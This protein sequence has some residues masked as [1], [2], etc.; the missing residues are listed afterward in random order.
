LNASDIIAYNRT[1]TE[2]NRGANSE[3]LPK[4]TPLYHNGVYIGTLESVEPGMRCDCPVSNAS[5]EDGRGTDY[6]H[7][8]LLSGGD[9]GVHCSGSHCN[10]T[11]I[12]EVERARDDYSF[13]ALED[14]EVEP[15]ESVPTMW[16]DVHTEKYCYRDGDDILRMSK[17][18]FT[19]LL[20]GFG[21]PKVAEV[22][23][24]IG[25]YKMDYD[26]RSGAMIDSRTINLF[27]PSPLMDVATDYGVRYDVP[28]TIGM[29]LDNVFGKYRSAFINWLAYI[30]QRRDKTGVIWVLKGA[31]GSGKGIVTEL[32]MGE[33]FGHNMA[34]NLTDVQMTSQFNSF[35]E[36][37]MIVHFNEISAEDKLSRVTVKNKLKTW[38]TDR[39][40]EINSK[41]IRE[42][43]VGN[44]ANIIIN[45]N[46]AIPVDIDDGDRRF[47]VVRTGEALKDKEWFDPVVS[48]EEIRREIKAFAMHLMTTEVDERAA[49]AAIE[50]EEKELIVGV[51]RTIAEEV[52]NALRGQ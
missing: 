49:K 3:Q 35:M 26:P 31:Q 42:Y 28:D 18:G 16:F 9:V 6:A 11:Y 52:A 30:Y 24:R 50:N 19:Q 5:H 48:I 33:I 47:S 1:K 22:F 2:V 38:A 14:S 15:V 37:K 25:V 12:P 45:T 4:D 46:E 44:F 17:Q 34:K 10:C 39:T 32:I 13:D 7:T 43:S 41:G 23:N 8:V 36:G 27:S 20:K 21:F 51:T 29:V 40:V